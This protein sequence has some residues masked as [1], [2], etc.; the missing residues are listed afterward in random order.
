MKTK[1]FFI[2][3][4]ACCLTV[5]CIFVKR[6]NPYDPDGTNYD[7]RKANH[8]PEFWFTVP[9]D[10]TNTQADSSITVRWDYKDEDNDECFVDLY[11]S[12]NTDIDS[13]KLITEGIKAIDKAYKWNCIDVPEGSYYLYAEIDDQ[14]SAIKKKSIQKEIMLKEISK[15]KL[16]TNINKVGKK[17]KK[18]VLVGVFSKGKVEISHNASFS[19]S[20]LNPPKDGSYG[21]EIFPIIWE[22]SNPDSIKDVKVDFYYDT[23]KDDTDMTLIAEGIEASTELYNWDCDSIPNGAYYIYAYVY[24][25]GSIMK[26][27]SRRLAMKRPHKKLSNFNRIR[28]TPK[29]RLSIVGD[30]EREFTT[31]SDSTVTILHPKWDFKVDP[32]E[33][34]IG[35]PLLS[36]INKR[37]YIF[38]QSSSGFIYVFNRGSRQREARIPVNG[39]LLEP[40]YPCIDQSGALFVSTR[41]KGLVRYDSDLSESWTTKDVCTTNPT[42]HNDMIYLGTL[43]GSKAFRKDGTLVSTIST[44]L[45]GKFQPSIIAITDRSHYIFFPHNEKLLVAT[46]IDDRIT[47]LHVGDIGCS[48]EKTT[49]VRSDYGS[50]AIPGDD[51]YFYVY[52][53]FPGDRTRQ[54]R[55]SDDNSTSYFAFGI[56]IIMNRYIYVGDRSA[57]KLLEINPFNSYKATEKMDFGEGATDIESW[58]ISTND[59]HAYIVLDLGFVI[60]SSDSDHNVWITPSMV[61]FQPSVMDREIFISLEKRIVVYDVKT[62]GKWPMFQ[63]NNE[64]TGDCLR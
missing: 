6:D 63:Y 9:S 44:T 51:S 61:M 57:K 28:I 47:V 19:I 36:E 8:A 17:H 45:K 1:S 7:K 26:G 34:I 29:S 46:N 39:V 62:Q 52:D 25:E 18:M 32:G 11:Y 5:N 24:D 22:F 55:I 2:L 59:E 13:I 53:C 40:C 15:I 54:V 50:Y 14:V 20:F 37:L 43:E 49:S 10:T 33:K 30:S 3:L 12:K 64:R 38:T 23:D 21:S 48:W 42:M 56:P 35:S 27:Q 4:V 16:L 60:E 41:D 31:Y 58:V